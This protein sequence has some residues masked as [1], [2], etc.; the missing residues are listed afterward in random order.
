[1]IRDG[2]V[3]RLSD[4]EYHGDETIWLQITLHN[5]NYIIGTIYRPEN[6]TL[7][8]WENLRTSIY[9]AFDKSPNVIITGDLNVDLLTVTPTHVF[10]RYHK[11]F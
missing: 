1:M 4:L 7:P 2:D 6:S 8:F 3:T 11:L 5:S 10:F 9:N